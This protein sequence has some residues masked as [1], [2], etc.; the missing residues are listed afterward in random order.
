VE[1]IRVRSFPD[2]MTATIKVYLNA[3]RNACRLGDEALRRSEARGAV[4]F[5]LV[6]DAAITDSMIDRFLEI[7]P[8]VLRCT[9]KFDVIIEE[10]ERAYVLGLFFA[11]VSSAVVS[12]ERI[13][14]TARIEL[15]KFVPEKV[16]ELWNKSATNDWQPN[17]DALAKWKYISE[18]LAKELT[19]VYEV[20]CRYLHSGEISNLPA[21][22]LRAIKAAYGLI[23]ELIGFPPKLFKLG[24]V[25]ECIKP[26]DPLVKA[27][28]E[29]ADTI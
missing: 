14:N 12:T 29:T 28:Y 8:P 15:H 26:D 1:L 13:L 4:E 19:E 25:I 20:R 23:N 21:D 17:I 9:T 18:D 6:S 7:E 22:A 11:A 2:S 5:L 24:S 27:F 3:T 10:V 16:K